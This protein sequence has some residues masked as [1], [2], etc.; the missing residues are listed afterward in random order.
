MPNGFEVEPTMVARF[1][2]QVGQNRDH[3]VEVVRTLPIEDMVRDVHRIDQ[4]GIA[5]IVPHVQR[6]TDDAVADNQKAIA[7]LGRTVGGLGFA[8]KYYAE[9]DR[10]QARK[11]DAT[12][13]SGIVG[14]TV[15]GYPT[16]HKP[17]PVLREQ[18]VPDGRNAGDFQNVRMQPIYKLSALDPENDDHVGKLAGPNFVKDVADAQG[19]INDKLPSVK[20]IR[21]AITVVLGSDM[22]GRFAQFIAGNWSALEMLSRAFY[23]QGVV[24]RDV[25]VNVK[26]GLVGIQQTWTGQA[27]SQMQ[28]RVQELLGQGLE[29]HA[30]FLIEASKRIREFAKATYHT[31]E[32]INKILDEIIDWAALAPLKV[33][34]HLD[35]IVDALFKGFSG[36]LVQRWEEFSKAVGN[37]EMIAHGVG[38]LAGYAN[39]ARNMP[40]GPA[41]WPTGFNHPADVDGD[42]QVDAGDRPKD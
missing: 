21:E 13:T 30:T 5:Y 3:A 20:W 6:W 2:V 27:A 42:G 11:L 8:E 25:V 31:F 4:A 37:L 14:Y 26:R 19:P 39:F 38:A 29:P 23:W 41:R 18:D 34:K 16:I 7:A 12:Y 9:V 24:Y 36:K 1:R 35:D 17:P 10:E 28:A 15:P 22:L 32:L 33:G 40:S